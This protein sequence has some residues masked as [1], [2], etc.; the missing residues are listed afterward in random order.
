LASTDLSEE[1]KK[2][3]LIP[4]SVQLIYVLSRLGREEEAV[5]VAEEVEID[6]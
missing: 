3:E 4:I 6:K 5:S 2:T 1:E